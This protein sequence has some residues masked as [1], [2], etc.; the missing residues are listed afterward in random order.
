M[1]LILFYYKGR[2]SKTLNKKFPSIRKGKNKENQIEIEEKYELI[3]QLKAEYRHY[4]YHKIIRLI[5]YN[6]IDNVLNMSE[7][8]EKF[9][10]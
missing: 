6:Q 4:S 5:P 2:Y 10:S 1:W 7:L 9:F 8:T 3:M